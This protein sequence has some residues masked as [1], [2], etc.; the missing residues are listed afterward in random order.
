MRLKIYY[1]IV[2]SF[3]FIVST[4]SQINDG[5]NYVSTSKDKDFFTL[6]ES[7]KSTTLYIGSNDYPGVIRALNDLKTDI[8]KVTDT[9]PE[10]AFDHLPAQK[11]LVIVGTLGKSPVIDQL[12]ENK[13]LDVSI[14]K[15]KWNHMMDQTRVNYTSWREPDI[16]SIPETTRLDLKKEAQMRLAIEGSGMW[17]PNDSTETVLPTFNSYHDT[18]FYVEVFNRG[19]TPFNYS[20]QSD[21]PWVIVS[22]WLGSVLAQERLWVTTDWEKAPKGKHYANLT[23]SGAGNR[24]ISVIVPLITPKQK[25]PWPGKGLLKAMV[26]FLSTLLIMPMP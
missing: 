7:G 2:F 17:W 10:I 16:E 26:T 4:F 20:V 3:L 11:E 23:V 15:G 12:V 13:K 21:V 19:T 25:K 18:A 6:S 9:E 5:T 14:I 24:K 1:S 8:G 22:S